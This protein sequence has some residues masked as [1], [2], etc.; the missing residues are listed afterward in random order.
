MVDENQIITIN[1][2][3][4]ILNETKE[5]LLSLDNCSINNVS[6]LFNES[7]KEFPEDLQFDDKAR[8]EILV[9]SILFVVAAVGNLTVFITLFRNRH[10]KSRVNLMIMHLAAADLIVTF[11]MIP[12][13]VGWRLTTQW[14]A[15]N[16]ACKFFQFLRAFGL[17][18]S[19]MVLVCISLDRY[20]AIVH[21]LKVILIMLFFD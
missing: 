9:Y 15:G 14:L 5:C 13:E 12:M 17:Y 7:S 19:S 4:P 16:F 18:L 1:S 6:S 20:F 10:R 8:N 21:P 3:E 11:I 2:I